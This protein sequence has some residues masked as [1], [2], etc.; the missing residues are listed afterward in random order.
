VTR[1]KASHGLDLPASADHADLDRDTI[2]PAATHAALSLRVNLA[3]GTIGEKLLN[4]EVTVAEAIGMLTVEAGV[5]AEEITPRE[6]SAAVRAAQRVAMMAE[7]ERHEQAGQGRSA[8]GKVAKKFARD[9]RDPVE[10]SSLSRKMREWRL[11][12][13]KKLKKKKNGYPPFAASEIG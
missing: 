13:K 10:V 7:M 3:L 1:A 2:A 6:T 8:A 9:P 12:K 5:P 11:K 4:R